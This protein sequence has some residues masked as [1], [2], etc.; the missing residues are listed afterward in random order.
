MCVKNIENFP[1]K[2]KTNSV[3]ILKNDMQI[4]LKALRKYKKLFSFKKF[5][6]FMQF[7]EAR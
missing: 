4:F 6:F 1:K 3:N 7:L 5:G 2:K